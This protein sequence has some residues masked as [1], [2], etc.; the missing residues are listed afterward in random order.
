MSGTLFIRKQRGRK[1]QFLMGG[2]E[3]DFC[4]QH[5]IRSRTAVYVW[6]CHDTGER[7]EWCSV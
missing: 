2:P 7:F 6:V 5:A 4:V 1:L 3:L